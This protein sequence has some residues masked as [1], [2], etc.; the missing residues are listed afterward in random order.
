VLNAEQPPRVYEPEKEE[1]IGRKLDGRTLSNKDRQRLVSLRGTFKRA[2]ARVK[3]EKWESGATGLQGGG[4][5]TQDG[6]LSSCQ[7]LVGFSRGNR[8]LEAVVMHWGLRDSR[9]PGETMDIRE[10]KPP[11]WDM[12][13]YEEKNT[14][15]VNLTEGEAGREGNFKYLVGFILLANQ[16]QERDRPREGS[17]RALKARLTIIAL[18]SAKAHPGG[19]ADHPFERP[20]RI[21]GGA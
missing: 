21:E 15:D 8:K 1:T 19:L 3:H 2:K 20:G 6:V 11:S 13:R 9:N 12:D 17:E 7:E 5:N 18:S 16:G 4:E 10:G 14:T